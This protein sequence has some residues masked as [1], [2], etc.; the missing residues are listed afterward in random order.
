ML[1]IYNYFMH[2]LTLS[3]SDKIVFIVITLQTPKN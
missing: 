3:L 1:L 2:I